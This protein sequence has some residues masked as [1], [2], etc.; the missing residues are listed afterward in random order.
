MS[1]AGTLGM[2]ILEETP[3]QELVEE[4]RSR[5]AGLVL[6]LITK[7][8]Y[9]RQGSYATVRGGNFLLQG[10]L[11]MELNAEFRFEQKAYWDEA[12]GNGG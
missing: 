5:C 6:G 2:R 12:Q 9:E 8:D 3:T 1:R 4:L 11:L 7:E 10:G